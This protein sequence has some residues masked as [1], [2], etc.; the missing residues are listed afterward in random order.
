MDKNHLNE[1]PTYTIK[2]LGKLDLENYAFQILRFDRVNDF[3]DLPI[4]EES[5]FLGGDVMG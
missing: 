1:E 3:M 2:S 5:K 4:M